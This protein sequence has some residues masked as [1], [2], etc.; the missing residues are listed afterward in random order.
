MGNIEL[1]DFEKKISEILEQKEKNIY[2]R[3]VE[4]F[5]LEERRVNLLEKVVRI[6]DELKSHKEILEKILHQMDKRFNLIQHNMDKR[7]EQVDNNMRWI[8]DLSRWISG[9]ASLPGLWE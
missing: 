3:L 6:G 2:E 9:S 1:E 8:N 7:F 5:N 4:R